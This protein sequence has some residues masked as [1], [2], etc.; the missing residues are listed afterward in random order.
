MSNAFSDK[1]VSQFMYKIFPWSLTY[2]CGG[3][4][5]LDLFSNWEADAEAGRSSVRESWRRLNNEAVLNPGKYAQ[6]L[7]TRPELQLGADWMLV[8]SAR[9][10]C[11]RYKVL[12]NAFTIVRIRTSKDTDHY[13]YSVQMLEAMKLIWKE[14]KSSEIVF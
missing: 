5:L 8:T 2:T 1:F 4:D 11:W 3:H 6:M 12:H 10:L 9:N 7:A 14:I 13:Q